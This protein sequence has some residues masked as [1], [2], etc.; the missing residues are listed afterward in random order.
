MAAAVFGAL[1]CGY[2]LSRFTRAT[3]RELMLCLATAGLL[4]VILMA[5]AAAARAF[6]LN[7]PIVPSLRVGVKSLL[8]YFP[9]TFVLEEVSFRGLVDAHV[10]QPGA[11]GGFWSALFVSAGW[12]LWHWPVAARVGLPMW[13]TAMQLIVIHTVIG[14]PL[15]YFWRRSGNLAVPG[16]THA[17]IDA[18]RN[19]LL[20]P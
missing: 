9:V 14:V 12:G 5:G 11:S 2:A 18:V 1:A 15:S 17:F 4:G 20:Q 3:T 13:L 7:E 6:G 19:A 16:F 8:L 10:H